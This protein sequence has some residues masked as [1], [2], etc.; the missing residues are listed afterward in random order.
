MEIALFIIRDIITIIINTDYFLWSLKWPLKGEN[1]LKCPNCDQLLLD[2]HKTRTK[3]C[4]KWIR[5]HDRDLGSIIGP[6]GLQVGASLV[7]QLVKDPPVNS[8]DTRDLGLIPGLGRPFGEGSGNP[9]QSSCLESSMDRGVSWAI[10][11]GSQTRLST[12]TH[13]LAGLQVTRPQLLFLETHQ[14]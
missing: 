8:G 10:I 3:K 12:N 13:K 6:S 5:L 7:A 11:H 1:P 2:E 9:L 4:K 14:C